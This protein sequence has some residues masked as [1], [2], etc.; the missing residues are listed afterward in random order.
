MIN[1]FLNSSKNALETVEFWYIV[2]LA[3]ISRLLQSKNPL[4]FDL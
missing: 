4:F 3:A 1:N 2:S